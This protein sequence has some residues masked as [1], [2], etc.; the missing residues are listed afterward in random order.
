MKT[1]KD[2]EEEMRKAQGLSEDEENEE[3]LSNPYEDEQYKDL[4]PSRKEDFSQ[5]VTMADEKEIAQENDAP[6]IPG[7]EDD[8]LETKINKNI[9]TT[10]KIPKEEQQIINKQDSAENI[11][12]NLAEDFKIKPKIPTP[13]ITQPVEPTNPSAFVSDFDSNPYNQ[14]GFNPY[15]GKQESSK[16]YTNEIP[17]A[18]SL[19]GNPYGTMAGDSKSTN[20]IENNNDDKYNDNGNKTEDAIQKLTMDAKENKNKI[21][22]ETDNE[23]TE[24][25]IA[26][27][28]EENTLEDEMTQSEK[29][30][31]V[32]DSIIEKADLNT[33]I[34][35]ESQ[36]ES[37]LNEKTGAEKTG[38]EET[39]A[40]ETGTEE[41]EKT[42]FIENN[43]SIDEKNEEPEESKT[44][45]EES[46][47]T[48]T[49]PDTSKI[50][51]KAMYKMCRV[52]GMM[53]I[54]TNTNCEKC[55]SSL[56]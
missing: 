21:A 41:T 44:M 28:K 1:T 50:E 46:N 29:A 47:E 24:T 51:P 40:E 9:E 32:E 19:F 54:S 38:A 31:E 30:N 16:E 23:K 7:F 13:I 11:K 25:K 52:C 45:K 17:M 6:I 33:G 14:S 48:D 42:E 34:D 27:E 10:E 36:E 39:G 37:N 22:N 12:P 8:M 3:E 49:E 55:G 26:D 56:L 20:D 5:K 35:N 18:D 15:E 53:N 4:N 2:L 43:E